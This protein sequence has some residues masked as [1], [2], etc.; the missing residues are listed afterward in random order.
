M[1]RPGRRYL[2][3]QVR[4]KRVLTYISCKCGSAEMLKPWFFGD[5][6]NMVDSYKAPSL[7]TPGLANLATRQPSFQTNMLKN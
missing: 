6:Q 3:G 2:A 1:G 4:S 5:G 7:F